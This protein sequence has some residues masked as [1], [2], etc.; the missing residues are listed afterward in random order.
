MDDMKRWRLV[1]GNEVEQEFDFNLFPEE[2]KIDDLLG[3]VYDKSQTNKKGKSKKEIKTWLDEIRLNFP[4]NLVSL[5]QRDALERKNYKQMLLEPELLEKVEP[6][7]D[8]VKSILQLQEL[9]PEKSRHIA[10]ELV[11]K[12][13]REIEQK[14]KQQILKAVGLRKKGLSRRGDPSSGKVDWN[15]TIQANLKHYQSDYQTIIPE[16]WFVRKNNY[17]CKEIFLIIDTSESMIESAIYSGIIGSIL[18]SLNSVHTHLIF[19]NEEVMDFSDKYSDPTDLLFSIPLGGGTDISKALKYTLQ[20]VKYLSSSYIF[21][22][23]DM[24]E[25]GSVSQLLHDINYILQNNGNI[26]GIFGLDHEGHQVVNRSVADQMV[27]LGMKCLTC[28]PDKFPGIVM[29]FLGS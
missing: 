21:L 3:Q 23:S 13:V 29:E 10:R 25:Y 1:L 20:K 2:K 28:S 15:K 24:D 12:L 11:R 27:D 26:L 14:M 4:P 22:I 19:F 7:I 17:Q 9:L 18:A 6:N 16:Q 5:L 8:L